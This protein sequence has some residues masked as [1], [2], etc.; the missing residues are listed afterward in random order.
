MSFPSLQMVQNCLIDFYTRNFRKVIFLGHALQFSDLF[1]FQT[2]FLIGKRGITESVH[3][4][5]LSF[6]HLIEIITVLNVFLIRL[7]FS[8]TPFV[9]SAGWPSPPR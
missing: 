7:P 4:F 3:V 6:L 9:S 2:M 5:V 8:T 1:T